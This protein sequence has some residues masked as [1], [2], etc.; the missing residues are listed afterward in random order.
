[1]ISSN[2]LVRVTTR[3]AVFSIHIYLFYLFY[4]YLLEH[5]CCLCPLLIKMW[6]FWVRVIGWSKRKQ[7]SRFVVGRWRRIRVEVEFSRPCFKLETVSFLI[8][9]WIK[10]NKLS[11]CLCKLLNSY[12]IRCCLTFLCQVSPIPL[13]ASNHHLSGALAAARPNI[14]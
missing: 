9:R 3:T 4:S 1:M 2:F 8:N 12:C 10:N 13:N 11:P 14:F 7:H 6:L 5:E